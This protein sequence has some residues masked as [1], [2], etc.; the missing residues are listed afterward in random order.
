MKGNNHK[1]NQMK[2]L[3]II[4]FFQVLGCLSLSAQNPGGVE[5]C[6]L[7]Q[8]AFETEFS[9]GN[10]YS[11][12]NYHK[13]KKI[14]A[15]REFLKIP[16]KKLGAITVYM[17]FSQES[18]ASFADMSTNRKNIMITD[19]SVIS[20]GEINYRASLN[21][22]KFIMFSEKFENSKFQNTKGAFYIGDK[23]GSARYLPEGNVAELIIYDRILS[24]DE[25]LRVES[26][27]SFK[28]G[29]SLP[30]LYDYVLS[31]GIIIRKASEH[32]QYNNRVT[33]VM[34]DSNSNLYQKQSVNVD[35]TLKLAISIDELSKLN[36]FNTAEFD[37]K[38]GLSWADNG[39]K[40]EFS[41]VKGQKRHSN[42]GRVWKL[43]SNL[44]KSKNI[45]FSI[46]VTDIPNY[47]SN[48]PVWL[49]ID[50]TSF[51]VIS[52]Q[53][54][55]FIKMDKGD[56]NNW[57]TKFNFDNHSSKG[58]L[59]TFDQG[60]EPSCQ[61]GQDISNC[62]DHTTKVNFDLSG[63]GIKTA[64]FTISSDQG[65]FKNFKIN[66][67]SKTE[68]KLPYGDYNVDISI[69]D[70]TQPNQYIKL[71][72]ILCNNVTTNTCLASPNPVKVGDYFNIYY[73]KDFLDT[74]ISN[75][76]IQ[77]F[78]NSG[79]ILQSF[80]TDELSQIKNIHQ[81]GLYNIQV[82]YNGIINHCKLIVF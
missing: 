37:D 47:D 55:T 61:I 49:V 11:S 19:T 39:D 17:V 75:M 4:C 81:A 34:R 10:D 38:M 33:F 80:K 31:D 54:S 36:E 14:D 52:R 70:K 32:N 63:V 72:K 20:S 73:N 9:E 79:K 65:F 68:W 21:K 3:K 8:K 66:N 24:N 53:E 50:N 58:L 48:L 29:I 76:N 42:I 16:L 15:D 28:Y 60:P 41:Q 12:F 78:D 77:I 67:I 13:Y 1:I 25:R 18:S 64:E 2:I 26:Y 59:F 57:T 22:A 6:Y 74:A 7:W 35:D 23:T 56:G 51:G 43:T 40:L 62:D 30:P 5:G 82:D 71:D 44:N 46:N 69:N 27:L 45:M